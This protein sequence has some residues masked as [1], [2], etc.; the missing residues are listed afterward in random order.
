[1][2]NFVLIWVQSNLCANSRLWAARIL[3]GL[4]GEWVWGL[5]L[6]RTPW[7]QAVLISGSCY[8]LARMDDMVLCVLVW[9]YGKAWSSLL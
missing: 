3:P 1:M 5:V 4:S 6:L 9:R 2:L 8:L 7:D